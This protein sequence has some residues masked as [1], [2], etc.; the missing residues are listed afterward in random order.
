MNSNKTKFMCFNQDGA[1]SSLT[2]KPLADQFTYLSSNISS[3]ESNVK[4]CID[5][6]WTAID[7]LTTLWKSDP[8][9]KIK[10]EFFQSIAVSVLLYGCT[11]WTLTK[12]L[13]KKP[14]RIKWYLYLN[15]FFL[16][17]LLVLTFIQSWHG[18]RKHLFC[19]YKEISVL[20][21]WS[22]TIWHGNDKSYRVIKKILTP[23]WEN[24]YD[25]ISNSLHIFT[26]P[27]ST[28]L[29]SPTGD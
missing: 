2:D 17:Q 3:T 28:F 22:R 8:S 20:K 29:E 12:H 27:V 13:K 4:I 9:D 6:A 16:I 21:N 14:G 26:I 18:A 10:L 19:W 23:L 11:I 5:K 24:L 1:I 7:M 25:I 15:N